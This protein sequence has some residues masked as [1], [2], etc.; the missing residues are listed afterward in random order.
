VGQAPRALLTAVALAFG[1]GSLAAQP[2]AVANT[3]TRISRDGDYP[4][5]YLDVRHVSR[6]GQTASIWSLQDSGPGAILA[7]DKPFLSTKYLVEYDCTRPVHRTLFYA[8]Y[9]GHMGQGTVTGGDPK[10]E[11]WLPNPPNAPSV[12]LAMTSACN[13]A[14]SGR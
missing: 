6:S 14:A 13:A 9:S 2:A 12:A 7:K 11:D 3:W 10:P 1:A 5:Q 4:A 8:K